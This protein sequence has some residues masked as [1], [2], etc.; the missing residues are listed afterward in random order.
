MLVDDHDM[1]LQGLSATLAKQPHIHITTIVNTA[2]VALQALKQDTPDLLITDIS[3]PELNGVEFIKIVNQTYPELKILVISM[4]KQIQPFKGIKGYLL[5][6]TTINELLTAIDRIVNQNSTYFYNDYE[7][8]DDV[9]EFQNVILTQREKDIVKLIAKEYTTEAI[10]KA[11]FISKYT[12][13]THK[14]NIYLKLKV[15]N[16]AGL[17]KKAVYLGYIN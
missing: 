1:F 10:G 2:K 5:K 3:M 13:E 17:I 15:N 6:E 4:F 12:V 9:L 11:L 7:T 14:K 8:N 16:A